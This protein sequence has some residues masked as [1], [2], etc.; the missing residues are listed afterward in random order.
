MYVL[1]VCMCVNLAVCMCVSLAVC[2]CVSLAVCTF[3]SR[4]DTDWY[5]V[6]G[7]AKDVSLSPRACS[8]GSLVVFK[9]SSDATKLEHVH[10][11]GGLCLGCAC[12]I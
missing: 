9:F 1:V 8:G 3:S 10:T 4:P 7:T 11:V 6:V 12:S 5:V 2:M